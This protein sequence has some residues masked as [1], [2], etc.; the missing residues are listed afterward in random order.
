MMGEADIIDIVLV[1]YFKIHTIQT[2]SLEYYHHR[3]VYSVKS[4]GNVKY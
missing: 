2:E 3:T 4:L 1:C